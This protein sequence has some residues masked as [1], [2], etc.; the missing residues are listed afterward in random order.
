[1]SRQCVVTKNLK[2]VIEIGRTGYEDVPIGNSGKN[3]RPG[4]AD[5]GRGSHE[6]DAVLGR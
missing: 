4:F 2:V 6:G 3:V 1:V 5:Q